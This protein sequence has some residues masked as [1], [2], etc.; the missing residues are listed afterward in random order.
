MESIQILQLSFFVSKEERKSNWDKV[1][2]AKRPF[3]Y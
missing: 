2:R 3:K 1:I